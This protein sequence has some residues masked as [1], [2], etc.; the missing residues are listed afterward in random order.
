LRG[1][2]GISTGLKYLPGTFAKIDEVIALISYRCP[3][4]RDLYLLI[5]E[6]KVWDL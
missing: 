6:K 2:F 3:K 1:L 4:W 5:Y